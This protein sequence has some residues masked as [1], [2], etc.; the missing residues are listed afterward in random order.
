[1]YH[2]PGVFIAGGMQDSLGII[3]ADSTRYMYMQQLCVPGVIITMCILD[4][5]GI[6]N[7]DSMGTS[8]VYLVSPLRPTMCIEGT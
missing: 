7:A 8:N 1:M 5:H 3:N 6:M 2:V 4:T